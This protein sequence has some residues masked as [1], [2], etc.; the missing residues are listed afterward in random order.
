[1]REKALRECGCDPWSP[2]HCDCEVASEVREIREAIH[3]S[4]VAVALYDLRRLPGS[5]ARD[6]RG[7]S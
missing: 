5:R 6:G 3:G 7:A 4:R 1:M 2:Y